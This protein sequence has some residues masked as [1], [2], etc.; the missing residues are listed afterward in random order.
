MTRKSTSRYLCPGAHLSPGVL[1]SLAKWWVGAGRMARSIR[2][3]GGSSS[4]R[5]E[6]V[7]PG[8]AA[9][10]P[11]AVEPGQQLPPSVTLPLTG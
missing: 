7:V 10:I 3:A 4:C 11:S 5:Y 8:M 1:M 2:P 6:A 9:A